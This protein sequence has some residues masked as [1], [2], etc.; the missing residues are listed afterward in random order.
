MLSFAAGWRSSRVGSI[1]T[2]SGPAPPHRPAPLTVPG[3][4]SCG[5]TAAPGQRAEAARAPGAGAR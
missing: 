4:Q 2:C 1:V 3:V 5:E